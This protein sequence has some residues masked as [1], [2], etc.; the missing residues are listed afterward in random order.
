MQNSHD[1]IV[2]YDLNCHVLVTPCPISGSDHIGKHSLTSVTIYHITSIHHFSNT[3][4]VIAL[5]V[6]PVVCETGVFR[7]TVKF[8]HCAWALESHALSVSCYHTVKCSLYNI[9]PTFSLQYIFSRERRKVPNKF[10]HSRHKYDLQMPNAYPPGCQTGMHYTEIKLFTNLRS[11]SI[12]HDIKL[13][14]SALIYY[15][16]HSYSDEYPTIENSEIS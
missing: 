16:S 5:S 15:I 10:R 12:N 11:Q 9:Y 14:R 7:T 2:P 1:F 8:V 13:L 3:D 4:T 6:V